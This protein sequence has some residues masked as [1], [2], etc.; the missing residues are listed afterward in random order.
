MSEGK[1]KRDKKRKRRGLKPVLGILPFLRPYLGLVGVLLV[2]TLLFAISDA[3]RAQ[4]VK[5]LLNTVLS[6]SSQIKAQAKDELFV[7]DLPDEIKASVDDRALVTPP[8]EAIEKLRA[9]T[10]LSGVAEIGSAIP[11]RL[12][13]LLSVTGDLLVVTAD[14]VP[15]DHALGWTVLAQAV[16]LQITA[17]QLATTPEGAPQAKSNTA[18]AALLSMRARTLAH[19]ATYQVVSE[20]LWEVFW[21]A[22]GLAVGLGV[23]G[24]LMDFIARALEAKVYVDLQNKTAAHLLTLSIGY[25]ETGQRGDLLSRLFID[26]QTSAR[27]ISIL[28][29][30][31]TRG[32]HVGVLGAWAIWISWQL[33]LALVFV[34][35]P[36]I[37]VVGR[38]GKRIRRAARTRQKVRGAALESMQQIFSGFREVK[39]FQREAFEEA[40][41]KKIANATVDA[42]ELVIRARVASKSFGQLVNDLLA[43][44]LFLGGGYFVVTRVWQLD[45]GDFGAFLALMAL[46]YMPAKI[47]NV[48]YN[49]LMDSLPSLT[50][51]LELFEQKNNLTLNETGPNFESLTSG[52]SF[53]GVSFCYTEEQT[54]LQDVSFEAA[55]GTLTAVVGP[56]G[57]GKSTLVDLIMRVRD[58][59]SGQVLVDGVDLKTVNLSSYRSLVAVVPQ[60]SF[61]FNDSI[62]ENIRYG[63]KDATD[64]EVEEAA[65][66]ACI[67][68]EIVALSE[69]YETSAGERGSRLS[70]GQIQRVAIARAML[71]R[72]SILILDEA[73]SALDTQTERLVQEALER[74]AQTTTTFVVAHRLTTIQGADQILVLSKGRLVEQGTHTELLDSA[75][76]YAGLV[77]R[78]LTPQESTTDPAS[79][80]TDS[81]DSED[82]EGD[83]K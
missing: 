47:V 43:P 74:V 32:I 16:D 51:V 29:N 8:P 66:A 21:W 13:E 28:T 4:L 73:A 23:F 7:Y 65:R 20:T 79:T 30:L 76:V 78:Q 70:G 50:R 72:P 69:G 44:V 18:R 9:D 63:R 35:A 40:R 62:R 49:N 19:D 52:I 22:F 38:F 33:A 3:G 60:E 1:R 31:L 71:K 58:P 45:V 39:A 41:F 37:Y 64:A 55:A 14:G 25:F 2:V 24:F 42:K 82:S 54:V 57:S 67:H 81:T 5:P 12:G 75:G 83:S 77:E 11:P 15:R 59:S 17:L 10:A 27:L 46:L 6:R 36:V 26:L 34:A 56:T 61:L 68:D 53:E 48:A 80:P